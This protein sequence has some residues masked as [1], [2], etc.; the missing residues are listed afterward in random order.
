MPNLVLIRGAPG[1]GK[2][3]YGATHYSTY[4]MMSADDYFTTNNEYV[5]DRGSVTAAH[6]WC[7]EETMKLLN[8]GCDV[9]VCNIFANKWNVDK[10]VNEAPPN[11]RVE[12]IKLTSLYKSVHK[13]PGMKVENYIIDLALSKYRGERVIEGVLG[14]NTYKY[15]LYNQSK[16]GSNSLTKE[17]EGAWIT[18]GEQTTVRET[19]LAKNCKH[20]PEDITHH[21]KYLLSVLYTLMPP[22]R[23][24]WK[25]MKIMDQ[26][27]NVGEGDHILILNTCGEMM[28]LLGPDE[29]FNPMVALDL[30]GFEYATGTSSSKLV[31]KNITK[32]K[33][34][35][36]ESFKKFPR[37]YVF[38]APD[39]RKSPIGEVGF[40]ELVGSLYEPHKR[41]TIQM[42]RRAFVTNLD[43]GNLCEHDL[44][45]IASMM[46]VTTPVLRAYRV[47]FK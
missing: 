7:H 6:N 17:E 8:E 22:L 31:D 14:A 5:Y 16:I 10:Y 28:I 32:V 20:H 13:V 2:S 42:L 43:V 37:D 33:K 11:T 15:I 38:C 47:I 46:R 18:V 45:K 12:V 29:D 34:V 44:D 27:C 40:F 9:V 1:S 21:F 39:D 30:D 36:I 35:L 23:D 26:M 3:T 19:V 24:E 41:T 25:S 4:K